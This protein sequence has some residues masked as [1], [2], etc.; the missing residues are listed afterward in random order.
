MLQ[1]T[2][3]ALRTA[4][5]AA[6][7]AVSIASVRARAADAHQKV[8]ETSE[9]Y[10][11]PPPAQVVALSLGHRAALADVLWAHVLVSQGLHTMERR[12]FENLTRLLDAINEL[13]PTFRDP[14]LYADA[15]ITIQQG[16]TPHD[17]ILKARE[18]LERGMVSRPLDGELWLSAGQFVGF[19]APSSYLTDPE[20]QRQWRLDGAKMLARAVE[21]GGTDSSIAWQ[22]LGGAGIFEDAGEREATIRF[23]RRALAVTED[24][25]LKE[26]VVKQLRELLGAQFED[27]DRKRQEELRA[28]RM[29]ELPFVSKTMFLLLGPPVDPALC[30]GGANAGDA[31]C[32]LTWKERADRGTRAPRP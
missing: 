7:A 21:L 8:K 30:A 28:M 6:L 12:R 2:R 24:E 5:L 11:L 13:D 23:L 26:A 29:K 19:I 22:A 25:E 3:D 27:A 9:I 31:R 1:A 20:E 17:E 16:A 18:I 15:L 14:Y 32:A 10:G 4:A